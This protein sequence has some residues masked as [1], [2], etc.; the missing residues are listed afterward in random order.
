MLAS[1]V[2]R[3]ADSVRAVSQKLK[4]KISSAYS[5][6]SEKIA[7]LP[8]FVDVRHIAEAASPQNFKEKYP[9]FDSV[10]LIASRLT[11]EKR[12]DLA[13]EAI[14]LVVNENPLIGLVITGEGPEAPR[15]HEL[16][17]TLGLEQN[18][19]FE[20]WQQDPISFFKA[21][22]FFVLT[23]SYEGY[24]MTLIEA[25]A[26]KLPIVSSNV[27]IAPDLISDGINS[28]LCARDTR[29]C[30]AEK[31]LLLGSDAN[32]RQA[33]GERIFTKAN[34]LAGSKEEYLDNYKK[35]IESARM[36]Q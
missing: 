20:G 36:R 34:E 8:I 16:V 25:A 30:F 18:V 32:L 14:A 24:G 5:I 31:I 23:S 11:K 26:A 19:F 22:D 29:E 17:K 6:A 12:I 3:R 7:V 1:F 10:G 13:L 9:G 27:G 15:L 28:F 35:S 2:I 33:F 21:S 4:E